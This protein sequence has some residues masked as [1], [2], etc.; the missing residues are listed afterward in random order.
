MLDLN[1]F[2]VVVIHL[3][4]QTVYRIPQ[5]GNVPSLPQWE[6]HLRLLPL[7]AFRRSE[8]NCAALLPPT[9]R[10]KV[11]SNSNFHKPKIKVF[12]SSVEHPKRF[13]QADTFVHEGL[14]EVSKALVIP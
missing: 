9:E 1:E 4:K 6:S 10:A 11:D 8:E 13:R 12:D 3:F 7:A 14:G 5:R 2:V